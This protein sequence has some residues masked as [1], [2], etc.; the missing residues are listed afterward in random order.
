MTRNYMRRMLLSITLILTITTFSGCLRRLSDP[1]PEYNATYASVT[2]I[3]LNNVI[4]KTEVLGNAALT[5]TV[6]IATTLR[7]ET[8]SLLGLG[9]PNNYLDS[10]A[11]VE[12]MEG[13]T[14]KISAAVKQRSFLDRLL[15]RVLPYVERK[16]DV[17]AAIEAT[18]QSDVGNIDLIN[19]VGDVSVDLR[20]GELTMM[21]QLGLF[22]QQEY[23]VNVGTLTINL[24][25]NASFR[26]DLKTSL[27]DIDV[28]G[29]DIPTHGFIGDTAVGVVG[30][31]DTAASVLGRVDVGNIVVSAQ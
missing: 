3:N 30:Y 26:Y 23:K 11:I 20:V 22:G 13:G 8:Y 4:G 7:V 1:H 21:S 24:P 25:E 9:N 16:M 19:L 17:P 18:L 6:H 5:D 14:L 2:A 12:T 29:F 28:N 15:V 27:G 31:L 10:V